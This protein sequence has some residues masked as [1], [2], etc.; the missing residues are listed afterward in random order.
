[1]ASSRLMQVLGSRHPQES[2]SG[3]GKSCGQGALCLHGSFEAV[4]R[5]VPEC[6]AGML[7]LNGQSLPGQ[8]FVT[9]VLV[10]L[11]HSNLS[12][13]SL[14]ARTDEV[15]IN[16]IRFRW[17]PYSAT[18]IHFGSSYRHPLLDSRSSGLTGSG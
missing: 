12:C 5:C 17:R 1:M 7:G 8:M 13:Y 11:R 10:T 9:Q 18:K 16:R 6:R 3:K 4:R 14:H 2:S 15:L